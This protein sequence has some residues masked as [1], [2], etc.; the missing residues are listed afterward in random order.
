MK[1]WKCDFC[2]HDVGPYKTI[3]CT[4]VMPHRLSCGGFEL[5]D[6]MTPKEM[7]EWH[8]HEDL[9][10]FLELTGIELFE[11]KKNVLHALAFNK[12]LRIIPPR[13]RSGR[14]LWLCTLLLG[15]YEKYKK[16]SQN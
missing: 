10:R 2:K 1:F 14:T 12:D 5:K 8:E 6:R 15:E 13:A 9:D 3:A 7:A 16:E 4:S 11:H